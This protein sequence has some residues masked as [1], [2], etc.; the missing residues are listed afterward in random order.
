MFETVYSVYCWKHFLNLYISNKFGW[1]K[2]N[3]MMNDNV[4]NLKLSK[5]NIEIPIENRWIE[6]I[7]MS[8]ISI[9][10]TLCTEEM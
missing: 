7:I 9:W 8:S 6:Q 3:I 5:Y 1:V 10:N 4:D 2:S